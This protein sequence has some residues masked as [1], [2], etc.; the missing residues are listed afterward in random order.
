[1][2]GS[3]FMRRLRQ[4]GYLGILI[5]CSGDHLLEQHLICG[6]DISWTKV[7]VTAPGVLTIWK[8]HDI[9]G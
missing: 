9:I 4:E 1:M 2:V 5:G 7:R 6:A 8:Y 3:E